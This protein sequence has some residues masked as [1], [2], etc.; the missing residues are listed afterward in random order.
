MY[1]AGGG[2]EENHGLGYYL[3]LTFD[4]VESNDPVAFAYRDWMQ[5]FG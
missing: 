3:C 2:R 4:N 1:H 5:R